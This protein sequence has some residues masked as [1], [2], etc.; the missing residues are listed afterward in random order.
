MEINIPCYQ[1]EA[2]TLS[3][4]IVPAPLAHVSVLGRLQVKEL[5]CTRDGSRHL[6]S[7]GKGRG[8]ISDEVILQGGSR[9]GENSCVESI[10]EKGIEYF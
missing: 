3:V 1:V 4:D 9:A 7:A 6:T 2:G 10:E 8:G 5:I